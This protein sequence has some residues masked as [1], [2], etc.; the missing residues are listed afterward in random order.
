MIE[1]EKQSD[2]EIKEQ[3]AEYETLVSVLKADIE[4]AA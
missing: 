4:V 1:H 2:E 3:I